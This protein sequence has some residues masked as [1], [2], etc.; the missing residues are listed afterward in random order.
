MNDD[1]PA[2]IDRMMAPGDDA[3]R[4]HQKLQVIAQAL[5]RQIEDPPQETASGYAQFQR[6]AL[7]EDEELAK[8]RLVQVSEQ[9]MADGGTAIL[10]TEVTD[11]IRAERA[12]RGRLLDDQA[13]ILKATLEHLPLA[14]CLFDSRLRLLAWNENLTKMLTLPNLLANAIRYTDSGRVLLAARP[15]AGRV[16]LQVRDTGRGIPE[17]DHR[18]VF[19]EFKRLDAKASASEGLGLGLAIVDR[20]AAL[21]GHTLTLRSAPACGS[22][23]GI[24]VAT[25]AVRPPDRRMVYSGL[26]PGAEDRP[27]ITA[28]IVENDPAM[29]QALTGLLEQWGVN[30]LDVPCGDGRVSRLEVIEGPSGR[31]RRTKAERARVAA[32]SLVPGASVTDV[33]RQHGTTRWQVYDW[34]KKLRTGQ[35]V[36]PESVAALPMFAELVVEGPAAAMPAETEVATGVEIVVGDVVIRVGADADEIL[37]TRSIRAAR[38][39][40][41]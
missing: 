20:A 21:L 2:D 28:L 26:V 34:R 15:R 17:R 32:E 39:A 29:M 14:V 8:G 12:E 36:V 23:F 31:R 24:E 1:L 38:T 41:S 25:T 3:D 10:Q 27:E 18:L 40:T 30:V 6:A 11:L 7:L 13:A 35:L 33:A 19:A 22:T 4:R 5:I 37:L 16:L 9:R